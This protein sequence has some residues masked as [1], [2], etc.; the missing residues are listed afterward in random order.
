MNTFFPSPVDDEGRVKGG[1][2]LVKLKRD[3]KVPLKEATM[4]LSLS[5]ENRSSAKDVAS[6]EL[7]IPSKIIEL[8]SS[9]FHF[10]NIGIRKAVLLTRYVSLMKQWLVDAR[11]EPNTVR[12]NSKSGI[13]AIIQVQKFFMKENF[14]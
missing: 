3:E 1:V 12:I 6:S 5:Y 8:D 13:P 11:S 2:I 10:E 9:Q 14:L 7:R 4:L